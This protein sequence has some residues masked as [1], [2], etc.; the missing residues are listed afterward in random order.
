VKTG[1]IEKEKPTYGVASD[2]DDLPPLTV[3]Q[4]WLDEVH[5]QVFGDEDEMRPVNVSACVDSNWSRLF[6]Q[7]YRERIV[8]VRDLNVLLLRFEYPYEVDL[9]E[10][11]SKAALLNWT[12]HL[13]EKVW[14]T[15]ERLH[16]FI[17]A[18]AAIKKFNLHRD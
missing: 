3:S 10:I 8:Y 16:L 6:D 15:L 5:Q 11:N 14:M 4:E 18:V 17:E 1:T 9:D 2:L 12:L 13:T 7:F